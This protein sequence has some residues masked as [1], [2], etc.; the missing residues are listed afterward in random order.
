LADQNNYWNWADQSERNSG[1]SRF[2]WRICKDSFKYDG[3]LLNVYTIGIVIYFGFLGLFIGYNYMR[4]VRV[5]KYKNA[6]ENLI[7][8]ELETAREKNLDLKTVNQQKDKKIIEIQNLV[9]EKE[10]LTQTLIDRVNEPYLSDAYFQTFIKN[11]INSGETK[12]G[13]ENIELYLDKMIDEAKMKLH[14]GLI[15]HHD[16]PQKEQWKSEAI[17]NE[18][19]LKATVIEE[20]KGLYNVKLQVIST[21]RKTT[22]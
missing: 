13:N 14:K 12:K 17:N 21:N 15:T 10:Q 3:Q 18:R 2:A 4:L 19:E 6:D 22:H 9:H 5:N 11:L 1:I 7:R 16:D 20:T 8:R